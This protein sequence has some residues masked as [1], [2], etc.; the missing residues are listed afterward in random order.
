[1]ATTTTTGNKPDAGLAV[2][3]MV[4]H[5][6]YL[7]EESMHQK[8]GRRLQGMEKYGYEFQTEFEIESYL[9]YNGHK[10]TQPL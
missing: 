4:G 5:I 8:F 6:T 1:M 7:S 10:F 3:R 9:K 2:A